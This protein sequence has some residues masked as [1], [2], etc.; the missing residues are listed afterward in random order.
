MA[1]AHRNV[2]F[3][4]SVASTIKHIV[5]YGRITQILTQQQYGK[6]TI[7]VCTGLKIVD[8]FLE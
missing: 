4:L 2:R 5:S 1:Y 7:W 8:I 3:Y 6:R